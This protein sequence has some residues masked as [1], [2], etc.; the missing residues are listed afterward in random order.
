MNQIRALLLLSTIILCLPLTS[1][2]ESGN[3]CASYE[4]LNEAEESALFSGC[5]GA[6]CPDFSCRRIQ[7]IFYASVSHARFV[8]SLI[9]QLGY[10]TNLTVLTNSDFTNSHIKTIFSS[11]LAGSNFEGAKIGRINSENSTVDLSNAN[12]CGAEV[13][14]VLGLDLLE[15][16]GAIFDSNTKLPFS[17]SVALGKGMIQK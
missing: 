13:I 17:V 4:E 10:S 6:D 14:E 5:Q 1:L 8:G 7:G 2:A 9:D 11:Q 15:L 3:N 12:L 16:K